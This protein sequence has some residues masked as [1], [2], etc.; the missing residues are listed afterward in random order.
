MS[1]E[2]FLG[3]IKL[4]GFNFAPRGHAVC[5]GQIMSIAQNSALFALLGTQFGGNGQTTFALPDLQGRVP[6]GQGSGPGLSPFTVGSHGGATSVSLT[7]NNLPAHIHTLLS[8]SVKLQ[9]STANAAESSPDG[10]YPALTATASY[11]DTPTTNVYTGG[12]T[13]GGTTDSTGSGMPV[14]V[15]NPY[16]CMNYCI[17]LEGIFPSRN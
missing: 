4:F 3:E 1:T 12:A 7:T 13:V 8:T 16:L 5:D 14:Q 2:P 17:A 15:M 10:T 11:A 9:A 6:I